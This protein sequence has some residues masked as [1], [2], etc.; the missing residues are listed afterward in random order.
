MRQASDDEVVLDAELVSDNEVEPSV[1]VAEPV[2][3]VEPGAAT[4][5]GPTGEDAPADA[6]VADGAGGS[7]GGSGSG[8]FGYAQVGPEIERMM[9]AQR[10]TLAQMLEAARGVLRGA[11][12]QLASA[13]MSV[14]A[15]A[16][17]LAVDQ[18]LQ[19]VNEQITVIHQQASSIWPV[20]QAVAGIAM[21]T[22]KDPNK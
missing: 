19:K 14:D 13:G 16:D 21:N 5:E 20:Q 18:T 12:S 17:P 1:R 4:G 7:V 9:A 11:S 22:T 3:L 8:S 10:E 2:R 15:G 6:A